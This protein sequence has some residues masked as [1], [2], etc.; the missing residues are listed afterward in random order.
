MDSSVNWHWATEPF[1]RCHQFKSSILEQSPS[2]SSE[3]VSEP[4]HP[5]QSNQLFS[6]K[7]WQLWTSSDQI[8]IIFYINYK[9]NRPSTEQSLWHLVT[10]KLFLQFNGKTQLR[11]SRGENLHWVIL[12][13]TMSG[14]FSAYNN[15][16]SSTHPLLPLPF[17]PCFIK[18]RDLPLCNKKFSKAIQTFHWSNILL[19]HT[20]V[21]FM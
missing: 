14:T 15:C 6:I 2:D 3:P 18:E 4:K 19:L 16:S 5:S 21:A 8:I 17:L 1:L 12:V 20:R 10:A 9:F 11:E 7:Y 13:P